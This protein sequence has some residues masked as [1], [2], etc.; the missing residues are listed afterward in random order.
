M[1]E[2]VMVH[3]IGPEDETEQGLRG[4]WTRAL[5]RSLRDNGRAEHADRLDGGSVSLG[6]AYYRHLFASYVPQDDYDVP[7][8][9]KMAATGEEVAKDIIDNIRNHASN[10]ADKVQAARALEELDAELGP[11]QGP[12]APLRMLVSMLGRLGPVARSGF[13]ALS[14]TGVFHLGQVAAYLHDETVREGAIE[15]VLSQVSP[16]TKAVVAHSLGTVVA[17]EALHRLE[18]PL[19]L[20]LTFGSPLGL[21]SI[22]RGRLRPQPLSSPSHVKRWVNVAD[23]DDYIVATLRLRTLLPDADTVLERT[24]L[25]KNRNSR[26]HSAVEYLKHW[27][28]VEPLAELL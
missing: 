10:P 23:R 2:L 5:A 6:M 1:A 17:Y 11:V 18:Q 25:V 24:R 15:A 8:S 16:D 13:A 27:Q 7:L 20:L 28:T 21:R 26:P 22:I 3:G 12:Y 14:R 4:D 9:V 19:P